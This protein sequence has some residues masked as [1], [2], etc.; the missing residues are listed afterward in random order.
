MFRVIGYLSVPVAFFASDYTAQLLEH[1]KLRDFYFTQVKPDSSYKP[2]G[3][4]QFPGIFEK[5]LCGFDLNMR[6][7]TAFAVYGFVIL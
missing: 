4:D 3:R 2:L 7:S 5:G 1:H 6:R